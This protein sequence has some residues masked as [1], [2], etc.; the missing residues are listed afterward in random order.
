M[1]FFWGDW[2]PPI[3]QICQSP[4]RHLSPFLDQ[5][6][7]PPPPPGKVRPRKFEK[8]KYIF[9]SNL[10]YFKLKSTF[11][12]L[13]FMLKIAKNGWYCIR[14]AVLASVGFL[15]KSPPIRLCPRREFPHQKFREKTL[16]PMQKLINAYLKILISN[17]RT[18]ALWLHSNL[19]KTLLS[20]WSQ[21]LCN[22]TRSYVHT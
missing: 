7:F 16:T 21:K 9:V 14:W 17:L 12:R 22:P 4:I 11:K 13:Y 15:N 3:R 10:T 20:K 2:G 8:S 5:G 1:F 6:L 18:L 19:E